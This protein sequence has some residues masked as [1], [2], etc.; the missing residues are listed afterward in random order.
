M[1]AEDHAKKHGQ[2]AVVRAIREVS[3]N[4]KRK[5]DADAGGRKAPPPPPPPPPPSQGSSRQGR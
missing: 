1:T 4:A 2:G 5:H 3:G